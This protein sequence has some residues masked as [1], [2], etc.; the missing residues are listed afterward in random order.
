MPRM[1]RVF[2]ILLLI[3]TVVIGAAMTF[4]IR[5]KPAQRPAS[6]DVVERTPQRIDRGRYLVE[7][8]L[9]CMDCHSKRDLTRYGGPALGP[10]G[11]G[12][13]C[14]GEQERFPGTLCMPNITPDPD[15]GIGTWTD[16]EVAR[17]IREGVGREGQA[18]FP[19]MPYREYSALSDEDTNAAVAYL[20]TLA[21]VANAVPRAHID[22]PV[23]YLIKLAPRPLA[24]P[25][26]PPAADRIATGKYLARISGCI[27]CHTPVDRRHEPLPGQELSGGQEF[28]GPFGTLRSANLTPHASGLGE[29]T[30]AAFIGQFKAF[31]V[32]ADSLP[33]VAPLANTVM[34]WASRAQMTNDDLGAIYA[35]LRS[36]PPIERIVEKRTAPRAPNR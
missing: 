35:Y 20:R 1:G 15:T 24:G 29:K 12:G 14:F 10:A 18:L 19:I 17:A 26:A 11:A 8:V 21:P 23:R 25:V 13:D 27:A 31:A 9:G 3:F 36:V 2:A 5:F 22:I 30:E 6:R 28:N 34:P 32:P 4:V 16:G 7:H 33:V